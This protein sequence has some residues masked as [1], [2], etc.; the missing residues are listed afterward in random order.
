VSATPEYSVMEDVVMDH[1][2]A[3]LRS[4]LE[5]IAS[6]RDQ[7]AREVISLRAEL[8]RYREAEC[9]VPMNEATMVPYP[10]PTIEE[11]H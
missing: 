1:V 7:L 4:T 9:R 2:R 8:K 5:P 6:Q 10:W 11:D 3:Y